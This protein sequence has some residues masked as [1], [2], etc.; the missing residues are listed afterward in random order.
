MPC[1]LQFLMF[2]QLEVGLYGE[3]ETQ[4]F[5]NIDVHTGAKLSERLNYST[6]EEGSLNCVVSDIWMGAFNVRSCVLIDDAIA[7]VLIPNEF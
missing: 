3:N 6:K 2:Q 5:W 4:I 1:L 7:L